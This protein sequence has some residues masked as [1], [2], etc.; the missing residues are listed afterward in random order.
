[1]TDDEYKDFMEGMEAFIKKLCEDPETA[2]LFEEM[3]R[4]QHYW[5]LNGHTP[6]PCKSPLMWSYWF[7]RATE[8]GSRIVARDQVGN[9]VCSTV[10][11]GLNHRHFGEG[12]PI[13][14]ETM[15]FTPGKDSEPAG[16][17][18]TWEEAE[19]MHAE[20][21]GQLRRRQNN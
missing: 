21:L 16:R 10:F 11:L 15:V 13:L 6:V 2:K 18:C 4:K 3:E 1:V 19:A 12:P 5:V 17:C 9:H 8:D 20:H 14:F 7:E